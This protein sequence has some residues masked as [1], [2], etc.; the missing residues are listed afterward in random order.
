MP[1]YF[2]E[3]EDEMR[4]LA[5]RDR[6]LR[7]SDARL[8]TVSDQRGRIQLPTEQDGARLYALAYD[9]IQWQKKYPWM[10]PQVTKAL[11]QYGIDPNSA[12]GR[13]IA[14]LG[15][16]IKMD[17]G[18]YFYESGQAVRAKH[19]QTGGHQDERAAK[20]ALGIAEQG[21][22][23]AYVGADESFQFLRDMGENRYVK[24]AAGSSLAFEFR[25]GAAADQYPVTGKK[26]SDVKGGS[27]MGGSSRGLSEANVLPKQITP[28][29][30]TGMM[31]LDAPLQELQG[32]FRNAVSGRQKPFDYESQS[33]LGVA[34]GKLASGDRVDVGTG[35]FV[36]PNSEVS[37]ERIRRALERGNIDGHTI[38][39]GR[40]VADLIFEPG[41]KPFSLLSGL[42][43]LGVA[44]A[45]DPSNIALGG[46]GKAR[47]GSKLFTEAGGIAGLRKTIS[48]AAVDKWLGGEQGAK[49]A[50]WLAD[51]NEFYDIH[52]ALGE[53]APID[54]S[55]QLADA[56]SADEVFDLLRPHLGTSLRE[57]PTVP[58]A[59]PF[60]VQTAK[61]KPKSRLWETTPSDTID[62]DDPMDAVRQVERSLRNIKADDS[63][64]HDFTSRMARA[65]NRIERFNVLEDMWSGA[66]GMLVSEY[67]MEPELAR[68]LTKMFRDSHEGTFKSFV[69]EVGDPVKVWPEKTGIDGELVRS[70]DPHLLVEHVSRTVSLPD[71]RELR[72]MTGKLRPLIASKDGKL[73]LPIA[74]VEHMQQSL[75]KPL[76][77]LR[78][79]WTVRIIGEEQ[80][81]MGATGLDSMFRHPMSAVAWVVGHKGNKTFTGNTL[82]EVTE[83]SQALTRGSG[84]LLHAPGTVVTGDWRII[85]KTTETISD[86][87]R[88]WGEELAQLHAD[89]V[90]RAVAGFDNLDDAKAW[91][92]GASG[93][94]KRGPAL[95][96]M[97]AKAGHDELLTD[98]GADAYIATIAKRL[99]IK[100]GGKAELIDAI[101]TGK[102]GDHAIDLTAT[103][104]MRL[105][106]EFVNALDGVLDA[107]PE[108]VKGTSYKLVKG[109]AIKERY[110][111]TI[112]FLFGHMMSRPT[113]YLSRSSTFKQFYWSRAPELMPF[114]TIDAQQA[115]IGVAKEAG[116]KGDLLRAITKS[117]KTTG[118]LS[119][120]QADLLARGHA[121]DKTKHLLYD[122][123]ERSQ[124]FDATRMIFP[125]GEAWKEILTRW[126]GIAVNRPQTIR[127]AQQLYQ[128]ARQPGFGELTGAP[129][130]Q[131]FFYENTQGEEVFVYPGSEWLTSG[132]IGVPV[133]LVGRT[134]GLNLIA[135]V[136]P[137]L[138]PVAAIPAGFFI[139]DTPALD[140]LN[141]IIFPYGR[142]PDPLDLRSWAPSWMQKALLPENLDDPDALRMWSN[143]VMDVAR[144]LSSTGDYDTRTPEGIQKLLS[145]AKSKADKFYLVRAA[146]QWVAPSSPAPEWL[147]NTTGEVNGLI[148]AAML[149][150]EFRLMQDQNYETAAQDFLAKYGEDPFMTMQ[151]KTHPVVYGYPVT[152]EGIDWLDA[153]PGV[154]KY[155]NVYGFFAPQ[156]G[157]F[158]Y[159]AYLRAIRDGA[160]QP[161]TP[162]QFVKLSNARLA[163][164]QYGEAKDEL[165]R[166]TEGKPS[167]EQ[168]A[169]LRQ[170][171]DIMIR[172][173]PGYGE[174]LDGGLG[175]KERADKD[176]LLREL[177]EANNN[178]TLSSTD[179]GQALATY[180]AARDQA[181]SAAT[182]RHELAT[183]RTAKSARY[184]RD[185]LREVGNTLALET[186]NFAPLWEQVLEREMSDDLDEEG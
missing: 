154:K 38:T 180:L 82:D 16:K 42:T 169:W 23:A 168:R 4:E 89:P 20:V 30:R 79:A 72:R 50:K 6:R 155:A 110:D 69:D 116:I 113:N 1:N 149:A 135:Q 14:E 76:A 47:A 104:Q 172:E 171:K 105:N 91:F 59:S 177:Y 107:G 66:K 178:P 83:A 58:G 130:G 176:Q 186:P 131:G 73:K 22:G 10:K 125:F 145:D 124:F 34:L 99:S 157:E 64:V 138:G 103:G 81:R 93:G 51:H 70:S 108:A 143:T 139:P 92:K 150:Q 61:A 39:P 142:P 33:D 17:S 129:A 62:L 85:Q 18:L 60:S 152:D 67:G 158:S 179:T 75:W 162:D 46:V 156:G 26:V 100:T 41:S 45:G 5:D 118:E 164:I 137:A 141:D 173:Y 166:K 112:E 28:V 31:I 96:K 136:F 153:N 123:T 44:V 25:E 151:S 133:P 174:L 184:L 120:E 87:R 181:M 119:L 175:L 11:A 49:V 13:T 7:D 106:P 53:K 160:K 170:V 117:R 52:K 8:G 144:Y 128:G 182:S 40:Y 71:A 3:V 21:L 134:Q 77:L 32:G 163:A 19:L 161:L 35:L 114:M 127:R 63:V 54:L 94:D 95:R 78:G 36:D 65:T 165:M 68:R 57:K 12:S 159:P 185:W 109:G 37:K 55:V 102:L 74:A 24:Q 147:V 115:L 122:L 167:K 48:P 140:D 2:P 27:A 86:Y 88:A 101:R 146:A 90:A 132:L 29:I 111:R 183:F 126:A 80:I 97:L 148:P 9:L 15:A 121:L 56:T 98:A 43:D 84:G